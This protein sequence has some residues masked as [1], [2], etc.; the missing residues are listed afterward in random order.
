MGPVGIGATQDSLAGRALTSVGVKAL[1]RSGGWLR[2]R[3]E[4]VPAGQRA[5]KWESS[6]SCPG[7]SPRELAG[8]L[9]STVLGRELLLGCLTG[10]ATPKLTEMPVEPSGCGWSLQPKPE[11]KFLPSCSVSPRPS[12]DRG[13]P[14]GR[15]RE[16]DQVHFT[17]G[18]KG[19][20]EAERQQVH[21]WHK[22]HSEA[23]WMELLGGVLYIFQIQVFSYCK[24]CK[25][26]LL[27]CIHIYMY[28]HT[29]T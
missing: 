11:S 2:A 23:C 25:Y 6:A 16:R 26:F 27:V 3:Q 1:G 12:P 7:T 18:Q 5:D 28:T 4:G 8:N 24:Y 14:T 15:G 21:T 17:G 13:R 19:A 20:L 29:H 22:P 9:P 10:D